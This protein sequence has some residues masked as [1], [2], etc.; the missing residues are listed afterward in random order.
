MK[1]DDCEFLVEFVVE[2]KFNVVIIFGIDFCMIVFVEIE[3]FLG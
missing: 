3:F 1:D 2:M